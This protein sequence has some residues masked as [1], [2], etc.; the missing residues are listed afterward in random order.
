ML[1]DITIFIIEFTT[2]QNDTDDSY[3]QNQITTFG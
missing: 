1:N 3:A 2:N